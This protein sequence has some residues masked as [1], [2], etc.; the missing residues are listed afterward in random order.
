HHRIDS[1]AG[2]AR[3]LIA[4][5]LLLTLRGTPVCYYGDEIG[6]HD[7][8]I[9]PDMVHDPQENLSPGYGRDPERSPMQWDAGTNASFSS[10]TPWLPVADDAGANNVA[11]QCHDPTSMLTLFRRLLSLRRALPPLTMG[12]QRT[13]DSGCDDVLAY[14]RG[15]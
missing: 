9:P 2:T 4:Q 10:V 3:E 14:L 5:M 11:G 1:R 15:A 13:L 7:V 6:M 12:D 8:P